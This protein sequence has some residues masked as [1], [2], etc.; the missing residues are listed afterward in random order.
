MAVRDLSP[1]NILDALGSPTRRQ[2]LSIL[3]DGEK[4]VGVIAK[5]LPVSRPAVSRH[6]R[7]LQEARLV[8][9]DDLG[10][11]NMYRLDRTGFDAARG[12][13]ERFWDDA[14]SR[15]ALVAENTA[16]K[17]ATKQ[18]PGRCDGSPKTGKKPKRRVPV[19][20][21][22]LVPKTAK[23]KKRK[24]QV[25]ELALV[26]QSGRAPKAAKPRQAVKR[27]QAG[28]RRMPRKES[29]P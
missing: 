28:K 25:P 1:D 10:A 18:A 3:G 23:A 11:H 6:L 19:A 7:Q 17:Q 20:E 21:L 4:S 24:A 13:L 22:A 9:Y 12:W 26:S 27:R 2:I 16:P 29:K 5:L 15:F 14:L 8:T